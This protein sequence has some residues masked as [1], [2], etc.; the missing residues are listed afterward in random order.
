M[1][2][3]LSGFDRSPGR[4]EHR[5]E[6]RMESSELF[7]FFFNI[8]K[9]L[10]FQE[11]LNNGDPL[12]NIFIQSED[13]KIVVPAPHGQWRGEGRGNGGAMWGHRQT[14]TWKL[15]LPI[16]TFIDSNPSQIY[17]FL[18]YTSYIIMI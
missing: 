17:I 14:T 18:R 4:R 13:I 9:H 16:T 11:L 3:T 6:P 8:S 10:L 2:G 7:F 5:T 15:Y 1:L 12:R